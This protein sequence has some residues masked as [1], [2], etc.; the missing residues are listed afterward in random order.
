MHA[1]AHCSSCQS[2][3]ASTHAHET[4]KL[5][6]SGP[7]EWSSSAMVMPLNVVRDIAMAS[8]PSQR[9]SAHRSTAIPRFE[10]LSCDWNIPEHFRNTQDVPGSN[11][12]F[13]GRALDRNPVEP[14]FEPG[15][16]GGSAGLDLGEPA[17]EEAALGRASN[18]CERAPVGGGRFAAPAEAAEQIGL[19]RVPEVIA[20]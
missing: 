16:A 14:R 13:L 18:A 1:V 7:P 20:G 4:G 3:G 8:I 2:F 19:G 17:L 12:R 6:S 11:Q 9:S 5:P 15:D 10:R